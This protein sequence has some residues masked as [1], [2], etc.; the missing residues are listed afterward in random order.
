VEGTERPNTMVKLIEYGE[1][2][3]EFEYSARYVRTNR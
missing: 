1:E 3:T 2:N